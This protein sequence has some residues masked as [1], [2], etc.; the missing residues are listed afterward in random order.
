MHTRIFA[1]LLA[2]LLLS[3]CC[4]AAPVDIPEIAVPIPEKTTEQT[5]PSHVPETTET[6]EASEVSVLVP[7]AIRTETP[8]D[9]ELLRAYEDAR[10][11]CWLLYG[12][13]LSYDY[14]DCIEYGGIPYYRVWGVE[15]YAAL[16]E[17][18]RCSFSAEMTDALLDKGLYIEQNGAVYSLSFSGPADLQCGGELYTVRCDSAAKRTLC[19][20]Q[21][22]MTGTDFS[23]RGQFDC[24]QFYE[25]SYEYIDGRWV[26]TNFPPEY[27]GSGDFPQGQRKTAPELAYTEPTL[28]T[29]TPTD[30]E[31]IAAF[32]KMCET[33]EW[34]ADLL[35]FTAQ[36]TEIGA[37]EYRAANGQLLSAGII[38]TLRSFCTEEAAREYCTGHFGERPLSLPDN[39]ECTVL[40]E[41][42]TKRVLQIIAGEERY[43]L[44]YELTGKWWVFASFDIFP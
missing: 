20:A 31:V 9:A 6:T 38:D 4:R 44:P 40:H 16:R 43:E 7:P 39:I 1:L 10:E 19:V 23:V 17:Y 22:R 11:A 3:A 2:A 28:Q 13:V 14:G 34:Y 36:N 29:E 24:L 25:Y 8:T 30:E 26:F 33:F 41:S 42:D 37:A 21:L 18:L 27:A 5:A 15:S 35:A 32:H 12:G